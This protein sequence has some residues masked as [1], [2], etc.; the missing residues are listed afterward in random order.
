MDAIV[1]PVPGLEVGGEAYQLAGAHCPRLD[2]PSPSYV[3]FFSASD[4][5]RRATV[6]Q[7]S[8]ATF[9][10]AWRH[11]YGKLG[12]ALASGQRT[13]RWA[14]VDWVERTTASNWCDLRRL[15]ASTKRNYFR[16]GLSLDSGFR[17]AFLEQEL[18]ANAM[19]YGGNT[20]EHAVVNEGNFSLYARSRFPGLGKIDFGDETELLVLHTGGLFRDEHGVHL[21]GSSGRDAGRRV[22]G[23]LSEDDALALIERSSSYL[24]KQVNAD[25]SFVYGHHPCFDRR[26]DAYNTLRHASTTYAMVEAWEVTRDDRLREAIDRSLEHICE[27]LVRHRR[28]ADGTE[29]AFLT[30]AGGEI[31]LGGNAVT[32]LALT[33]YS[34]VTGTDTYLPLAAKLADGMLFMQDKSDGSF[35][36]V[37][38]CRDLSVKD[39][40][41][42]IY[43][44]GE[45]AFALM[46]LYEITS[47]PRWLETVEKAFGHF[48]A[49]RHWEHHDH[50]LSYCVNELTRYRPE[51]RYFRFGI[52]NFATYLDFVIERITTF[53]TLLELMMA[54]EEMI[55]R[56]QSL[57]DYSHLLEAVDLSKFY[58]ALHTRAKYLLNGHFWPEMAMFFRNPNRIEGSFFIRHHAFRVRIDDVEHY[59][60]GFIAYRRFLLRGG[61]P[62]FM[63]DGPKGERSPRRPADPACLGLL[64]YPKSPQGFREACVLARKAA[65]RG[66]RVYY[67][68]YGD[69]RISDGKL[70]GY[71]FV[72]GRWQKADFDIPAIIDNAPPRRGSEVDLF[73][74]LAAESFVTCWK[75]G[76]KQQTLELLANDPVISK[77]LIPSHPFAM[78][79]LT[80]LLAADG[81]VVAKPFR[82]NRGRGVFLL[83][84]QSDGTVTARSNES[85]VSL[86]APLLEE[87]VQ[88]RSNGRWML[89][90]YV[91]SVDR[92]GRA[93][94]IRVPLIRSGDLSWEAARIYARL[95]SGE[96]T[97]N[98]ATGGS[99]HDAVS[100]LTDHLGEETAISLVA[101]LE[102]AALD[103]ARVLQ[104]HYP[105][106]ID[107]LGC[108]FG[109][110]EGRPYLFE[111]NSY[112]GM[113]GCLETATDLKADYFAGLSA[114]LRASG[115][116]QA[117]NRFE[118]FRVGADGAPASMR[119]EGQRRAPVGVVEAGTPENQAL[120]QSVITQ[121]ENDFSTSA[122]LRPGMGNPAYALIAD[123]A[124]RRGFGSRI[125]RNTHLE[126]SDGD[127]LRAIFSPNSPNLS[128]SMRRVTENKETTRKVLS[129]AGLPAPA[130]AA[131]TDHDAAIA[132]FT[133]RDRPQVLKPLRGS[134]GIGVTTGV[135]TL[136]Q[137]E[138]AWHRAL[139]RKGHVVVE[140]IA[141]GDELRLIVLGG[142]TVAAVCRLPAYVIGD[143][144]QTISQ[145]VEHKNVQ[146]KKNP[147]MRVYPISQFDS[148]E[149]ERTQ[150][151]DFVPGRGEFVRLSS[152]SNVALGGEAVSMVEVLHPSFLELARRTFE[153]FPGATQLG[154]DVIAKDFGA[155][156]F[157]DNATIIEV[158]SD[159][160]IGTP[161]FAAYGPPA[162]R[163]AAKLIDFV[164]SGQGHQTPCADLRAPAFLRPAGIY[165]PAKGCRPFPRSYRLQSRLLRDAA[166]NHGLD[167]AILSADITRLS[168]GGD[169]ALFCFGIPHP[170]LLAARR[171]SNDKERTKQLLRAAGIATPSGEVF[172]NTEAERAWAFASAAG[173]PV[174]V[175]P[176][177]GSGGKGVFTDIA[178][179][180]DFEIAW[181]TAMA[182]GATRI[183]VERHLVGHDYRLFV[184]QD[185][186]AAVARRDPAYVLGDGKATI[187]QLIARKNGARKANPYHGAKPIVLTNLMERNLR[188]LDLSGPSI[189]EPGRRLQLHSVANIGSGGESVDE[190][191]H[192][193]PGWAAIAARARKAIYNPY[194]A[195]IDLIAEDIS[196]APDAQAWSII[197]VNTNPD[198]GLHHFPMKGPARNVAGALVSSL[199]PDPR[200]ASGRPASI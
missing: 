100:F 138:K 58:R 45:A 115:D 73:D 13:T 150:G 23:S 97:S 72:R 146:R 182:A 32:I 66:L 132:Y 99:I 101:S 111:V 108:D 126:I 95:G 113:K 186:L 92:D 79:N 34:T 30:E 59:L 148:L 109:I 56:L 190:T 198:F 93:F 36:H 76:G 67:A 29:A 2:G 16:F 187:L 47:E 35:V 48:I 199:F 195:G 53:P 136:E 127:G 12:R 42:T 24:A 191:D 98:L 172:A 91:A 139:G 74:R 137:F 14:R 173:L 124:R 180:E 171:A 110:A 62:D 160:A 166:A 157:A 116:V 175:K 188:Q 28:L 123:E 142:E 25:G 107:A 193:H 192:A 63:R 149:N 57:P 65:D 161:R 183:I 184:I 78:E 31:K 165:A 19:L 181:R 106:M 8:A 169:N 135:A 3:L 39:R 50:W 75:L 156:A 179:R 125:V 15:L 87:F 17:H 85:T 147:L 155:D 60:S 163:I 170:T 43:Y 68:S 90:K 143:G 174:V 178:S 44:E 189:L 196:R 141:Y 133:G 185:G 86:D 81:R 11:C 64:M 54:A 129:G 152:V 104:A 38:N 164:K 84:R 10:E 176:L 70:N 120:I 103:M 21:L 55:N 102:R 154:L 168:G 122:F 131:F 18:N 22:I 105:F 71:A 52:D 40:F 151:M 112:P 1:H 89:Q 144:V 69:A 51:E 9:E 153:A 134:G 27:K 121:G 128:F 159:P 80:A 145:L 4:G 88:Q 6:V 26:I 37:L 158:N 119:S 83:E 194:H 82:S 46:R 61:T 33:K 20:V 130:G 114:A 77:W 167:I 94:D 5:S 197:E 140:D 49:S 200:E 117:T 96:V 7:S 177:I 162:V 41:R 118:H